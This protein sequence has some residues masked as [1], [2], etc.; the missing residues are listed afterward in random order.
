MQKSILIS[1]LFIFQSVYSF[2]VEDIKGALTEHLSLSGKKEICSIANK[3]NAKFYSQDDLESEKKLC[4]IDF[5]NTQAICPKMQSTNP[6]VEILDFIPGKTRIESMNYCQNRPQ[7]FE[8][9]AKFKSSVSC[10]YTPSILAYYHMSRILKAGRVPVAVLRT[11]DVK[12]HLS[13]AQKGFSMVPAGSV[14]QQTWKSFVNVDLN[15]N[16]NDVLDEKREFVYGALVEN[17]KSEEKYTEMNLFKNY[18]TRYESFFQLKPYLNVSSP[19]PIL[20]LAIDSLASNVVSLIVQMKDVSDM[21]LLDTLF[22]QQD[23]IGNIHYKGKWYFIKKDDKGI[24]KIIEEKSKATFQFNTKTW[25]IPEAEKVHLT[26]GGF[27]VKEMILKDND[28]GVNVNKYENKMRQNNAIENLKHMSPRTYKKFMAFY[29][30]ARLPDSLNWYSQEW[31]MTNADI[32]LT[33][34]INKK[35][36]LANLDRAKTVLLQNCKSG[37]LKL[38]LDVEGY[39]NNQIEKVSCEE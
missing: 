4:D 30:V 3:Q 21:V 6:G 34:P 36:F 17:P 31:L 28:C 15:L 11:M 16:N 20:E 26:T 19:K 24:N 1:S 9:I 18:E 14:I 10:S 22:T 29:K 23:R 32:G 25:N 27:L 38:D 35:S 13:V 5:Y 8:K 2:R 33:Q 39:L 37:A 7:N 12:E